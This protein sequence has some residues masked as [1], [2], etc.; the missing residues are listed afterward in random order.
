MRCVASSARATPATTITPRVP[1]NALGPDVHTS[2]PRGAR[3]ARHTNGRKNWLQTRNKRLVNTTECN[4]ANPYE[5]EDGL[6]G[7]PPTPRPKNSPP[8]GDLDTAQGYRETR[9]GALRFL[10]DG[11]TMAEPTTSPHGHRAGGDALDSHGVRRAPRP[12]LG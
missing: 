5:G 6:C 8:P 11:I 9:A 1:S 12:P 3:V 10:T 4:A 2:S 7:S